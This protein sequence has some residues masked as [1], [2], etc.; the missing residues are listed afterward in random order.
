[1]D[2]SAAAALLPQ[3]LIGCALVGMPRLR[4]D[5]VCVQ[6]AAF[7]RFAFRRALLRFH[8]GHGASCR[9]ATQT[10]CLQNAAVSLV[11]RLTRTPERRL[12]LIALAVRIVPATLVFGS[13][14]VAGWATWGRLLAAGSNPTASTFQVAWPPMWLPF[15]WFA[16]V[17][18]ET[19]HIPFYVLIKLIPIAADLVLTLILYA[20]AE[21]HGC[22]PW[23]TALAYALNPISIYCTAI[24]GQFDALPT[25]G[26]M[27]AIVMMGGRGDSRRPMGAAAWLGIGA[28]FKTWPLFILPALLAPLRSLRRRVKTAAVAIGIF[29]CALLSSWLFFGFRSV[30][31]ILGY[32]GFSGWWGLSS[33][34]YL[35]GVT[36]TA[37]TFSAILFGAMASTALLLIV[38]RTEPARGA[39][40][41]MLT[42]YVTAPGFGLQYLIWIVPLAL[43]ADQRRGLTYSRLAG[44]LI[45]CEVLARPYAGHVGDMFRNLPHAGYA[46]AYGGATDHLY[47]V[48]DRLVL[49]SFFCWWWLV[50]L[51]RT[52]RDR[53]APF[54]EAS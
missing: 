18:S 15:T 33:I 36:V 45:A 7:L 29:A 14:D 30:T 40:L 26:V 42:F 52:A 32:R 13:D 3:R 22:S 11:G 17:M 20:V 51:I 8:S 43:L 41:L 49:W 25:L 9:V 2:R 23:K 35:R 38:K 53:E 54:A 37:N 5:A 39:L 21:E 27:G 6:P 44:L 28:T 34:A 16:S 47:T 1:M 46:R 10:K 48:V 4:V 19:T 50:M 24:H 31:A 12:L